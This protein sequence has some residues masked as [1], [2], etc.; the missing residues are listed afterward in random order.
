M[1][2]HNFSQ[3]LN[4]LRK[5]VDR[6]RDLIEHSP[7]AL[8]LVGVDGMIRMFNDLA[9]TLFGFARAEVV[10]RP[11]EIL[12]PERL[13]E[14]HHRHRSAYLESPE[15]RPLGIGM[16]LVARRKDGSEVPVEISL[17]PIDTAEGPVILSAIR[18]ITERRDTESRLRV[19]KETAEQALADLRETQA[20][21][22]HA[23]KMASLGELTAGIAHEIKNPLNFVTN[24]AATS[25]ELLDELG[26]AITPGLAALDEE[27]R[28]EAGAL[29]ET[30]RSDLATIARHGRRANQIV[31]N[32]LMHARDE[33]QALQE[34]EVNALVEDACNL[35]YHGERA[36]KPE[37]TIRID[38][39]LDA[40]AG[41]IEGVSHD[42]TR[43]LVNIISNSFDATERR[44]QGAGQGY[45]P[46]LSLATTGRTG[47]VEIRI[48]DNGTGMAPEVAKKVFTP[49]FTTKPP[50]EGTGLGLSLSYDVVVHQHGGSIEAR[51]EPGAYTEFVVVLPRRMA[52]SAARAISRQDASGPSRDG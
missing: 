44:R 45:E 19:A 30:L 36:R 46:G 7:D 13:R 35:A 43:V 5:M 15:R 22:V 17:S 49:F 40:G 21:L 26:A 25:V 18:D 34:I 32:M 1:A 51:S 8:V 29:L 33:V 39:K 38:K 31:T 24:F 10:G 3:L 14:A 42:L 41:S 27:A 2:W 48:R 4:G 16:E 28:G 20:K 52:L 6:L 47:D 37:F 50:G 9:E 23:E 11:L 12:L